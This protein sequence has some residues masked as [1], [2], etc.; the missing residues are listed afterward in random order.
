MLDFTSNITTTEPTLI[1]WI[2]KKIVGQADL[3]AA[4]ERLRAQLDLDSLHLSKMER[5]DETI[6]CKAFRDIE[7]A[8]PQVSQSVDGPIN[9]NGRRLVLHLTGATTLTV[10]AELLAQTLCHIDRAVTLAARIESNETMRQMDSELLGRLCIGT[11]FLDAKGQI[12]SATETA[13]S[14]LSDCDGLRLR[15]G[16]VVATCA[17]SDRALQSA[18]RTV[19]A[20]PNGGDSEFLRLNQ[21][22]GDRALGLLVQ[23][24]VSTVRKGGIACALV[25]R[26][27]ERSSA[28][29]LDLLRGLFDLTPAEAGLTRILAMGHT[30]DEAAVDLTI[31]RNTARAHLRAIFSKCGINRQTELVRLVL[32]SVAMLQDPD[33]PHA[34]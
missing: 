6:L 2:Y 16:A 5:G 30:L 17:F 21:T 32:S 13:Q 1:D 25:I 28:P 23:P 22:E 3:P 18:I 20:N 19:L 27:S 24:V 29:G 33:L 9:E 7:I 14:M 8:R 26:D 12:V 15:N 11:I 34:A 10:Q 4:L 31:S